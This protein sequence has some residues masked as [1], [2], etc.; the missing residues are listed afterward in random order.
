MINKG[1]RLE[2]IG[3]GELRLIQNPQ[4]FCYGIDA[5]L[6]ADFACAF[7]PEFKDAVDLGTGTGIVPIIMS[8]KCENK[9]S[10]L[11]GVEFQESSVDIAQRSC[12]INGISHR[13]TVVQGDVAAIDEIESLY[14]G[15]ADVVTSNPPYVARSGGIPN[16]NSA[17]YIAR[18]ETTA[19]IEEFVRAAAWLLEDRGHFF[20]VHR[21]SRL[22]DVFYHCRK[23]GLEPKDLRLVAPCR[24]EIPNIALIHCISGGGV[25]LKLMDELYVYDGKSRYTREIET[26]Y[27]RVK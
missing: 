25:E 22:V 5:V 11:T 3:F 23:Y 12:E 21:P 27:E 2:E 4:E 16:K 17:R 10:R 7:C 24:G 26:I 20:L 19:G 14:K 15:C 18:H 13:I 6:L 9:Q 8:H 1:E